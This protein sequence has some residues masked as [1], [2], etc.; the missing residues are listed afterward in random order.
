MVYNFSQFRD[1]FNLKKILVLS[2]KCITERSL[3]HEKMSFIYNRNRRG[4]STEP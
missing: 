3:E 4:P 1:I 2:A